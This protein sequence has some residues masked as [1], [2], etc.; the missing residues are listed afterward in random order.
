MIFYF[1]L[2]PTLLGS[3][4]EVSSPT[5]DSVSI[6]VGV[7]EPYA[8]CVSM[9]ELTI[10]ATIIEGTTILSTQETSF[11]DTIISF[12]SI[13]PSDYTC[14]VTVEDGTGPIQ[15]VNISCEFAS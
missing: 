2:A 7:N 15:V 6:L 13:S 3:L 12:E 11:V 14:S 10:T 9:D 4:S 8:D 5:S 1:P